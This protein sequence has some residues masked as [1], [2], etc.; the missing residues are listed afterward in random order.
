MNS[1]APIAATPEAVNHDDKPY[2]G[3]FGLD[4]MVRGEFHRYQRNGEE[5]NAFAAW[6]A[7]EQRMYQLWMSID[8]ARD[9]LHDIDGANEMVEKINGTL[10]GALAI[11]A[12][13]SA[14]MSVLRSGLND[15]AAHVPGSH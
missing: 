12:T 9:Q 3:I 13:V 6:D 5:P 15:E 1:H 4:K 8:L 14:P 2:S 10:T 11:L 7:V